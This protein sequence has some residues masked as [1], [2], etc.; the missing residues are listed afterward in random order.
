M[1]TSLTLPV[2]PDRG[3]GVWDYISA[4][5]LNLWLK[6]PLAYK[7]RYIDGIRTPTTPSLFIGKR[8]HDALEMFYRHRQLGVQLSAEQLTGR[9]GSTW[10]EAAAADGMTFES[11]DDAAAAKQQ[12]VRL[13]E[14]YLEHVP[15]DEPMPLTV[16]TSLE[17]PLVD[18]VTGEDLG[19]K[20]L[21]IVDL[22]LDRQ[23]GPVICDF[24][25]AANSSP[26]LE[27]AHEIQLTCYA[28]LLHQAT[29]LRESSLEIRSLIKTKTPQVAFHAFEPRKPRHFRRLFA[30]IQAY[31]D[32]LDQQ[33]FIYRPGW[34]CGMCEFSENLCRTSVFAN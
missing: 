21:G 32:D 26:P 28:Y 8:T 11:A 2:V 1:T 27:L 12:V 19:I 15:H 33:R 10:D 16:E 31:L 13:V 22:V 34:T 3:D 5:R 30:V 6:C 24:K 9:I 29:G 17:A 20:L 7:F 18:P 23:D 14:T 4:S 25:T